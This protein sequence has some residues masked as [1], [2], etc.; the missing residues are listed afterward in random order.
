MGSSEGVKIN[1]LLERAAC[2]RLPESNFES[3]VIR[4]SLYSILYYFCL[5]YILL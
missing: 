5:S 4:I 2:S 3:I 1:T